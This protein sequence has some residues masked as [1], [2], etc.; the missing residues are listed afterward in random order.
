MRRINKLFVIFIIFGFIFSQIAAF[1]GQTGIEIKDTGIDVSDTDEIDAASAGPEDDKTVEAGHSAGNKNIPQGFASLPISPTALD[2]SNIIQGVSGLQN[3]SFRDAQYVSD[4]EA[5]YAA[6]DG[7]GV[8]VGI[9]DTG[10]DFC[11]AELRDSLLRVGNVS[12]EKATIIVK[13]SDGQEYFNLPGGGVSYSGVLLYKNSTIMTKD[14]D[15]T[16]NLTSGQLTFTPPLGEGLEINATYSYTPY[17]LGW[18]VAMD[19][20]SLAEYVAKGT[21]SENSWFADTSTTGEEAQDGTMPSFEYFHSPRFEMTGKDTDFN[22]R[23]RLFTSSV[24]VSNDGM[25]W[26]GENWQTA[27]DDFD[28]TNLYVTRDSE[29]WYFGFRSS[30]AQVSKTF[31]LYLDFDNGTGG[32]SIGPTGVPDPEGYHIDAESSHTS[33][34]NS[35]A[36]SQ[37]H[38]MLASC[39]DGMDPGGGTGAKGGD[40]EKVYLWSDAGEKVRVLAGATDPLIS[41]EWAP[42]GNYLVANS[43]DDV[44]VWSTADWTLMNST[45]AY[46]G[47]KDCISISPDSGS[48]AV[49]RGSWQFSVIDISD[50]ATAMTRVDRDAQGG[51]SQSTAY[52]PSGDRLAIGLNNGIIRIFDTAD[53]SVV[54]QQLNA[55]SLEGNGHVS[56]A[57]VRKLAWSPDGEFIATGGDDGRV[58][59]W[60]STTGA[61]V[62]GWNGT[63][64]YDPLLAHMEVDAIGGIVW[65]SG[66]IM[67][68]TSNGTFY[69]IDPAGYLID[70][71][72]YN[73]YENQVTALEIGPSLGYVFAGSQDTTVRL[74][75]LGTGIYSPFLTHRPDIVIYA[76][77]SAETYRLDEDGDKVI[78]SPDTVE[79]PYV[80]MWDGGAWDSTRLDD[81]SAEA[82]ELYY[83][84]GNKDNPEFTDFGFV[85]LALPRSITRALETDTKHVSV[86]LFVVNHT[87]PSIAQ[88]AVPGDSNMVSTTTDFDADIVKTM[89]WF[90][91]V[92]FPETTLDLPDELKSESGIYHY[93]FHPSRS[94]QDVVGVNDYVGVLVVD[95]EEPGVYDKVI[96]DLNPDPNIIKDNPVPDYVFDAS[97]PVAERDSPFLSIDMLDTG[98]NR[99]P[100]GD[101]I[102]DY[103]AGFIYHI[104]D[105]Q[106]ALPYSHRIIDLESIVIDSEHPMPIPAG[107]DVVCFFGE[108]EMDGFEPENRGTVAA[109]IIAAAGNV[110]DPSPSIDVNM[111]G[112]APGVKLIGVGKTAKNLHSSLHFLAEGFDGLP[113][114][115]DDASVIYLGA[116]EPSY[117]GGIDKNSQY[118]DYLAVEYLKGEVTF[119]SPAG[120]DGPGFGTICSP[121][122]KNG[123][124]IGA[125]QDNA[126]EGDGPLHIFG[127]AA[128]Y[129]SRG[130]TAAGAAKPDLTAVGTG[131]VSLPLTTRNIAGGSAGNFATF[132]GTEFSAAVTAGVAALVQQAY[133]TANGGDIPE[134]GTVARILKST[135][136]DSGCDVLTQGSGYLDALAAVELALEQDGIMLSEHTISPSDYWD[137]NFYSFPDVISPGSSI[138]NVVEMENTGS[139]TDLMIVPER[140][141]PIWEYSTSCGDPQTPYLINLT[142]IIPVNV[143][144]LRIRAM[145][146]AVD[147]Y[148]PTMEPWANPTF[149]LFSD[150]AGGEDG[151]V[152]TIY[153]MNILSRSQAS[154]NVLEVELGQPFHSYDYNLW[155]MLKSDGNTSTFWDIYLEGYEAREWDD[156]LSLSGAPASITDSANFTLDITVPE[157]ALPGSYSGALQVLSEP[158]AAAE[159]LHTPGDVNPWQYSE[160]AQINGPFEANVSSGDVVIGSE[161]VV[162]NEQ[163]VHEGIDTPVYITDGSEDIDGDDNVYINFTLDPVP[164]DANVIFNYYWEWGVWA[165]NVTSPTVYEDIL[166][167][168]LNLD[169]GFVSIIM[170][171]EGDSYPG[172][173]VYANYTMTTQVVLASPA[174]YTLFQ[175]GT[176]IFSASDGIGPSVVNITVNYSTAMRLVAGNPRWDPDSAVTLTRYNEASGVTTTLAISKYEFSYITGALLINEFLETDDWLNIT[177]T[178][179]SRMATSAI[180]INVGGGTAVNYSFGGDA[181]S[182]INSPSTMGGG[183]GQT[184][185]SGDR[186]YFYVS[187]PEQGMFVNKENFRTYF[188]FEWE[189]VPTDIDMVIYGPNTDE[190][191]VSTFA[192]PGVLDKLGKG[193]VHSEVADNFTT[194][195]GGANESLAT[196]L[197]PGINVICLRARLLDGTT[198]HYN[199]RGRGGWIWFTDTDKHTTST[200]RLSGDLP[201]DIVSN[202]DFDDGVYAS[203][204]GPA[205]GKTY[206]DQEVWPDEIFHDVTQE[207][208]WTINSNAKY[209]KEIEVSEGTLSLDVRIIG[210]DTCPDLDLCLFYDGKTGLEDGIA[211]WDEFIDKTLCDDIDNYGNPGASPAYAYSAGAGSDEA[212]KVM[213]PRPGTWI[214][215]VVGYDVKGSPGHFDLM[216]KMVKEGAKGYELTSNLEDFNSSESIVHHSHSL[217]G[218]SVNT[219]NIQWNFP[220]RTAEDDSYSGIFTFGTPYSRELLPL[221]IDIILDRQA[222]PITYSY[223]ANNSETTNPLAPITCIFSDEERGELD[224]FSVELRIDGIDVTPRASISTPYIKNSEGIYGYWG[225]VIIYTP[226]VAFE[227]G[228]HVVSIRAMDLAGNVRELVWGFT[229]DTKNPALSLGGLSGTVYTNTN[230]MELA[231]ATDFDAEI[232]VLAGASPAQVKEDGT[233]FFTADIQL[234]EG[235]NDI[236]VNATDSAGNEARHTLSVILDT[237]APEFERVWSVEGSSTRNAATTIIGKLDERGLLLINGQAIEVNS[238]GSFYHPAILEEGSNTFHMEFTDLAGNTCEDWLNIFRDSMPPVLE[239]DQLPETSTERIYSFTGQTEPG[240][241]MRVNGKMLTVLDNGSFNGTVMLSYGRNTL[242]IEAEDGCGNTA[243]IR[244]SVDMGPDADNSAAINLIAAQI[245]IIVLLGLLAFFLYMK[246]RPSA[247]IPEIEDLDEADGE[248]IQDDKIPD[249]ESHDEEPLEEETTIEEKPAHGIDED[250]EPAETEEIVDV[251]SEADVTGDENDTIYSGEDDIP[252]EPDLSGEGDIA[253]EKD[254][255]ESDFSEDAEITEETDLSPGQED[256]QTGGEDA[257]I[258]SE[259]DA[260]SEP[261]SAPEP[262]VGEIPDGEQPVENEQVTRLEQALEEGKISQE[263]YEKNLKKLKESGSR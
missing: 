110:E 90:G 141:V 54:S 13:S 165:W 241:I 236:V 75:D 52:S 74:F 164:T 192:A 97:D 170:K 119:V 133:G 261:D 118:I 93:G 189:N 142:N 245:V 95:T 231:G 39:A 172:T 226:T 202:V 230:S 247:D 187:I 235:V 149:T 258:S 254:T 156:W 63:V 147:F 228:G 124:V 160:L 199:F 143:S 260:A 212:T 253:E 209:A 24:P 177:Y 146:A 37:V 233:G 240:V 216:V 168:E 198:N 4:V 256:G 23:D 123:L 112:I 116:V 36:Y 55:E 129:S 59:I 18:P 151:G 259:A 109:G 128:D 127:N 204:L 248:E 67:I 215:K 114:T 72:F 205:I 217:P 153:E 179:F 73:R 211:Q 65:T 169:T 83:Y 107:G 137:S 86:K 238:D 134:M 203:V 19:V 115:G 188:S 40:N 25:Y 190:S 132:T 62:K 105:G 3:W 251:E 57:A 218:F 213:I 48:V 17:N 136:R 21:I 135:A 208:W 220:E 210:D 78:L 157:D 77:Y 88:D 87:T 201:I 49:A 167:H 14:V 43:E 82:G 20:E 221:P 104:S 249:G 35:M 185:H 195:S 76:P 38:N 144:L 16:V 50:P 113:G 183:N 101:G 174:N 99:L 139:P 158:L 229:V 150:W 34:V 193:P 80:H 181:D 152:P 222:P 6:L 225:M 5:S 227:D 159:S 81:H 7:S 46:T 56:T 242:V 1:S 9:A 28:L 64:G 11:K 69:E 200:N 8:V 131:R 180:L 138:S 173:E 32:A 92:E 263:L 100:G 44:Y 12:V 182:Y 111:T 33:P 196:R 255:M 30:A 224:S 91:Y 130:P 186:R 120:N 84:K 176:I 161:T 214:V 262:D 257:G 250:T 197:E 126:Y 41:V 98:G 252:D 66:S 45:G 232:G 122:P 246:V 42:D 51:F 53:L 89:S 106:H 184:S 125:A 27:T 219:F 31:G 155:L 71:I 239:L 22:S 61:I 102:P 96:I 47:L 234:M 243:E 191:P 121:A 70:D 206:S 103:S 223:P 237:R 58:F 148:K 154:S 166:I 94:L 79:N 175:N 244:H 85:E 145:T 26:D 10:V 178:Y 60:N 162:R 29:N 2:Y 207:D 68:G 140:S 194:T 15:Y 108:F 171:G 163:S 117:T